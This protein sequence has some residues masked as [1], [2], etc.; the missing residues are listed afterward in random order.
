MRKRASNDKFKATGVYKLSC[1]DCNSFYIGQTG[2]SFQTRFK[3]HLLKATSTQTSKFA[4]HLVNNNHNVDDISS[5][6]QVLHKCEKSRHMT[7]L[8]QMEIYNSFKE[9][10][11]NVLNE[12]LKYNQ[13]VIFDRLRQMGSGS[14]FGTADWSQGPSGVG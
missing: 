1:S 7:T 12:K 3:E 4:K 14:R 10:P 8:E 13:N 6:S 11:N 5:N 9:N 2:R